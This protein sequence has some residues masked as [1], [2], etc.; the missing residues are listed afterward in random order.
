[1]IS[2]ANATAATAAASAASVFIKDDCEEITNGDEKMSKIG[3]RLK[4]GER[5]CF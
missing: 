4:E 3:L 1:M 5:F 2:T